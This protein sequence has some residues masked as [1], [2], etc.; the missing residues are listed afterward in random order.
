MKSQNWNEITCSKETS[1]TTASDASGPHP[2]YSQ[3]EI[4]TQ[5]HKARIDARSA[6]RPLHGRKI[7]KHTGR[8][9]DITIISN[10][11]KTMTAVIETITVKRKEQ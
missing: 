10:I 9:Q 2:V 5:T 3:R 4:S 7:P 8:G 6:P 11:L 1:V